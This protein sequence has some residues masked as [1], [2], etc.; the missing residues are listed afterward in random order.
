MISCCTPKHP[1]G[2][3]QDIYGDP[4]RPRRNGYECP[5]DFF[6]AGAWAVIVVIAILHYMVQVP[7]LTGALFIVALVISSV[8]IAGVVLTKV[9]LELLPQESE[10]VFDDSVPRLSQEALLDNLAPPGQVPC[11]F[12][13]RFVPKSCKHCSMCDKCVPGFDHHCRWLNSCVGQRNYVLFFAFMLV[14][15]TGMMWVAA[16]GLYVIV[17]ALMDVDSFKQESMASRAYHSPPS[18]FPAIIIFNF[19]C[20]GLSLA[21]AGV[22]GKLITFHIYLNCTNQTT[23]DHI[24]KKR[25][26]KKQRG[27]YRSGETA[28][29]GICCACIKLKKRRDFKKHRKDNAGGSH[30]QTNTDTHPPVADYQNRVTTHQSMTLPDSTTT[31][32]SG[33][34]GRAPDS[35]VYASDPARQ[36]DDLSIFVDR[37]PLH[38]DFGM[39]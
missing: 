29:P 5:P 6:Q 33:K 34:A 28:V 17:T 3:W 12:C 14:A 11:V 35:N 15:W 36:D 39:P 26:R 8:L 10:V 1:N 2:E 9:A 19:V 38:I 22:L 27:E 21:G 18:A 32:Y 16:I 31:N 7:F 20:V 13:R 30:Q 37:E 4:V 25:E 23:L 24:M